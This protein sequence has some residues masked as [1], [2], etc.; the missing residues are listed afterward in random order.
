MRASDVGGKERT[1]EPV[2]GWD[3]NTV[4]RSPVLYWER[5]ISAGNTPK[6]IK[7]DCFLLLGAGPKKPKLGNMKNDFTEN[8]IPNQSENT[9]TRKG[10]LSAYSRNPLGPDLL[11]GRRLRLCWVV[12]LQD[13]PEHQIAAQPHTRDDR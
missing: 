12:F 8:N 7:G 3:G 1:K 11:A 4:S 2:E 5:P 10:L 6:K 13:E 9:E